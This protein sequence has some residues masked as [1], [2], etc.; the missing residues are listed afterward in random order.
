MELQVIPKESE[1]IIAAGILLLRERL[2][3]SKIAKHKKEEQ[4]RRSSEKS[5]SLFIVQI[6]PK[7]IFVCLIA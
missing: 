6:V 3:R 7:T 5:K 1:K 2:H 4:N